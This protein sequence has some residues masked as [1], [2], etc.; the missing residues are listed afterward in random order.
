[1]NDRLQR[2]MTEATRLTRAG[3]LADATAF[4]QRLLNGGGGGR[5]AADARSGGN[6]GGSADAPAGHDA[7]IIDV[8]PD[9]IEVAD[10]GPAARTGPSFTHAHHDGQTGATA[11]STHRPLLPAVL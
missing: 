4:L 10:L 1:M 6:A 9:K 2:G 11:E 3:R 7:Q 8:V 5:A